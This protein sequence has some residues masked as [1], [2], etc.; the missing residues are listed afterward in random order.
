MNRCLTLWTKLSLFFRK[1]LLLETEPPGLEGGDGF[2]PGKKDFF[3]VVGG[4]GNVAVLDGVAGR[5][6]V[7]A[8]VGVDG[9][10]FVGSLPFTVPLPFP[11]GCLTPSG[12]APFVSSSFFSVRRVL[13][14]E[15]PVEA[16]LG[17]LTGGPWVEGVSVC[18]G[19][20]TTGGRLSTVVASFTGI[21]GSGAFRLGG[22]G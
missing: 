16:F 12:L 7:L 19:G 14:E 9:G 17:L 18:L 2:D 5:T 11:L 8:L 3:G 21:M 15:V 1:L 22:A 20:S 4:E 10:S 13:E 6:G